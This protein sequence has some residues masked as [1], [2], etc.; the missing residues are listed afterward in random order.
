MAFQGDKTCTDWF[1]KVVEEQRKELNVLKVKYENL[2]KEWDNQQEHLGRLQGEVFKL[3]NQLQSQS[4]FCASL[5]SIMGNLVWRAS[6]LEPVIELLLETN[7]L[8]E[9][10]CVVSGTLVSFLDTYNRDIPD[11]RSD[12][13]QF[14]LSICGVVANIAAIPCGRHFIV[15]NTNGKDLLDQIFKALPKIPC[16]SGDPLK[17]ILLMVLYNIS[18]NQNGLTLLQ[19]QRTLLDSLSR[20]MVCERSAELKVLAL[21]L[22]ESITFDIPNRII[23]QSFKKHLP[24]QKLEGLKEVTDAEIRQYAT[25]VLK[26]VSKAETELKEQETR[27]PGPYVPYEDCML[28]KGSE[29]NKKKCPPTLKKDAV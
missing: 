13:S 2:Q 7:K 10:M 16:V 11:I 25:S 5:G 8:G 17:R 29:C 6:R 9:F 12:E 18:I 26:N 15:S 24:I 14:I 1:Q 3:R 19:E 27:P 21:R 4:S 20:I 28:A 23:L 22:L